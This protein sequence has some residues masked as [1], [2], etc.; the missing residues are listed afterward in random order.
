MVMYFLES[1]KRWYWTINGIN[2]VRSGIHFKIKW[3]GRKFW[4]VK[5][6]E[7]IT[8]D[9]DECLICAWVFEIFHN[10]KYCFFKVSVMSQKFSSLEKS[11]GWEQII[12]EALPSTHYLIKNNLL[13]FK[14]QYI[15]ICAYVESYQILKSKNKIKH[16]IFTTQ[17]LPFNS[18][19]YN[20]TGLFLCF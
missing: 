15:Y 14:N 4:E 12:L 5:M 1:L 2:Y 3:K 8:A 7:L 6:N 10:K 19:L 11:E 20:I 9:A 18:L 17:M 16:H 13:F